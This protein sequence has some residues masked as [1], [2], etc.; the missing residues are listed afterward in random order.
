MKKLAILLALG[1]VGSSL[2]FF[3]GQVARANP[4]SLVGLWHFDEGASDQS[5]SDSSGKG[6]TGTL[7]PT[8]SVETSDPSRVLGKFKGALSFDG[9][10]YVSVPHSTSLDIA[11]GT[12]EIWLK[13]DKKPGDAPVGLMNPLAKEEQYW[14]HASSDNSIQA[15]IN[16]GGTRYI[17]TTGADF[18]E[19]GVWHHVAGTYDGD[20][21]K[22]YVN[23][24]LRDSNTLPS[25]SLSVTTNILAI[26]TWSSLVDFFEGTVDEVRI[27]SRPLSASEVLASAQAGL[28][29]LW[30]F[31]EDSSSTAAD[32]SG[33]EN[34]GT[35]N[36]DAEFDSGDGRFGN[37]VTLDGSGD[38]VQVAQSST[39][40]PT[41]VTVEG[42]VKSDNPGGNFRYLLSKGAKACQA[43]S[44]ALYTGS[45]G[46]LFFYVFDGGS[47]AVLSS[48]VTA[49]EIWDDEWHH[50]AGTFDGSTV[51]LYLDG[52]EIGSGASTAIS[53]GYALPTTNDLF[54]GRYSGS[55]TLEFTGDVDELHIWARALSIEEIDFLADDETAAELFL[56]NQMKEKLGS[57]AVFTSAWQVGTT[58]RA[59]GLAFIVPDAAGT[60]I[61]SV[62]ERSPTRATPKGTDATLAGSQTGLGG[63]VALI[64]AD[65][66]DPPAKTLHLDTTLSAPDATKLGMQFQWK[67]NS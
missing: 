28:R 24:V 47:P 23:G 38:F 62:D 14:I 32:A 49:S 61:F 26:G 21:L 63:L 5:A 59:M 12:W 9:D 57:G 10:D 33:Y 55:C 54:I 17:A 43:A 53:I 40:E 30:H 29:A 18:I 25:G 6:N 65:R 3:G 45:T 11:T 4:T 64:T 41:E 13:F 22:L 52:E 39:L 20:A 66:G 44:Y 67:K 50:V 8:V 48:G 34:D 31:N 35:L 56:P 15:K 36:G 1:L 51:R 42:W 37:A 19:I 58:D 27:W 16:V 7:G 60:T 46:G 2:V